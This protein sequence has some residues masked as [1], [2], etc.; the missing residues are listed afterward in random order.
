MASNS[1]EVIVKFLTDYSDVD[2]A[3]QKI[4]L[5]QKE[6]SAAE[7]AATKDPVRIDAIKQLIFQT[8]KY[9]ADTDKSK[10]SQHL[11]SLQTRDLIKDYEK[12]GIEIQNIVRQE[13]ILTN[14]LENQTRQMGRLRDA[15]GR[16]VSSRTV[17]EGGAASE[18]IPGTP[19]RPPQ[20]IGEE[21]LRT[22]RHAALA[23]PIYG[24]IY[25][26]MTA[27]QQSFQDYVEFD[28]V[29]NRIAIVS[30]ESAESM[31][32][33]AEEAHKSGMSLSVTA[34]DYAEAALIFYQ[35]GGLAMENAES[36]A[37]ASIELSNVLGMSMQDSSSALTAIM[38]SFDL[39][40]KEG[41]KAGEHIADVL[42]KLDQSTAT[43]GDKIA[44]GLSRFAS[45]ASE[46]GF[47]F[48]K[49]AAMFATVASVTQLAPE[50]VG[51]AFKTL[52]TNLQEVQNK[53]PLAVEQYTNKLKQVSDRYNLGIKPFDEKGQL[54]NASDLIDQVAAA[55]NR[56]TDNT[57]KQELVQAVAGKHQINI[58]QA[59]LTNYDKM[60][61]S[62]KDGLASQGT[63]AEAQKKSAETLEASLTRLTEAWNHFT[64][65]LYDNKALPYIIDALTFL[66]TKLGDFISGPFGFMKF[67]TLVLFVAGTLKKD[68][69]SSI[70]T[71]VKT[72]LTG[73][74]ELNA[75]KE[76][77]IQIQKS[78]ETADAATNVVDK[79][80]LETELAIV[81]AKQAQ[82][83]LA[84]GQ[85]EAAA[86]LMGTAATGEKAAGGAGVPGA[87]AAGA[88]AAGG[89]AGIK[90]GALGALKKAPGALWK[91]FKTGGTMA[92][93]FGLMELV[94]GG[95]FSGSAFARAGIKTGL[96][97]A[98]GMLGNLIPIPGVG[99][100]LGGIAGAQAG[101]Y[102]ANKFF[103]K[104]ISEQADEATKSVEDFTQGIL[105]EVNA[106]Q[107]AVDLNE[108]MIKGL[109]Q[110]QTQVDKMNIPFLTEMERTLES[111]KTYF[112]SFKN[113]QD[114]TLDNAEKI[115]EFS[116]LQREINENLTSTT[117]LNTMK[118]LQDLQYKI[119]EQGKNGAI[120]TKNQL[121][122]YKEQLDILK[123]K[124]DLEKQ[125]NAE[126]RLILVR[127]AGGGFTYQFK[128]GISTQAG[129]SAAETRA[130][131]LKAAEGYFTTS[132]G[133]A[134]SEA[135]K[136]K[137]YLRST[138]KGKTEQQISDI[139]QSGVMGKAI[140]G[141]IR[142][143]GPET[144]TVRNSLVLLKKYSEDAR[145]ALADIGKYG[146]DTAGYQQ[147]LNM[148]GQVMSTIGLQTG[149]VQTSLNNLS[150][151]FD[152]KVAG[153]PAYALA[154]GILKLGGYMSSL[155]AK[156]E[157]TQIPK[158]V[159][160]GP[161]YKSETTEERVKRIGGEI[162][163]GNRTLFDDIIDVF[164]WIKSTT[165][166]DSGGYTGNNQG[167]AMLHSKELVLNKDDTKNIL[168]AVSMF[169]GIP[170]SANIPNFN[171]QS[172]GAGQN[173]NINANFPN[174]SSADEIKR[175]FASMSNDALQ[176]N[177]RV[178]VVGAGV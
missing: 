172:G 150:S 84:S 142:L 45:T 128:R 126:N 155:G 15:Q 49:A 70:I 129:P 175:A 178:K 160:S 136:L 156:V 145:E 166:F 7:M 14:S 134:Y 53:G 65:Q 46:A 63:A 98:G 117:N 13:N 177:S 167:M 112:E 59:L 67:L 171:R 18:K 86:V 107:K 29:L 176:F 122:Y 139:I 11:Y 78:I 158:E 31:K 52:I 146:G 164:R 12:L 168:S 92:G 151:I 48:E 97:V 33:F 77:E 35:Q 99:M 91:G 135:D 19:G 81:K 37:K 131:Q 163:A 85:A 119:A 114:S 23:A 51:T 154:Q 127:Q 66:I 115:I 80:R 2:K 24:V 20:T 94:G 95:D 54:V 153:T 159:L 173:V 93:I 120:A 4:K 28:K 161:T 109:N 133:A 43:S 6:L 137:G 25:S 30:G 50:V 26:G 102:I 162:T 55:Y 148:I 149:N 169:R 36:L 38:N 113:Y 41:D 138:L 100:V 44:A 105:D 165:S 60:D 130:S 124:V 121:D 174:V 147:Q 58:L 90:K 79:Q 108:E 75:L 88:A 17:T 152:Y 62:M 34:K 72:M 69:F 140:P 10:H 71:N 111:N 32:A 8:E 21:G 143:T 118:S 96:S 101:E 116:Q 144:E 27:I 106:Q 132:A 76:Q 22:A 89:L 110:L 3:S 123:K 83:L 39:L 104:A 64:K 141:N 170:M 40:A 87:V 42:T 1:Y 103:P 68:L 73:Q 56:L 57:A 5:L 82:I 61:Q 9:I 47:T 16:F 125:S 74:R 157:P